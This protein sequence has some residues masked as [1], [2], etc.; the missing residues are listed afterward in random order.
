LAFKAARLNPPE[1]VS[2]TVWV[3]AADYGGFRHSFEKYRSALPEYAQV[4][5]RPQQS[6]FSVLDFPAQTHGE[7]TYKKLGAFKCAL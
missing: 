6:E 4:V 2:M 3:A 1:S 5:F 7:K